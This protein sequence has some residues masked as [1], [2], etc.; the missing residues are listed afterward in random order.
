MDATDNLKG[1]RDPRLVASVTEDGAERFCEDFEFVVGWMQLCDQT[2]EGAKV[3]DDGEVDD[4]DGER[5]RG[6]WIPLRELYPRT[7]Q[8]VRVLLS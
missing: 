4:R 2:M 1:L 5:E 3:R 6:E 8:E 7:V